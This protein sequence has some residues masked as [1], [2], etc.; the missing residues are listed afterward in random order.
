MSRDV[1][2][3]FARETVQLAA[4]KM[5]D[6]NVGFLPVIDSTRRVLGAITDRD[7][8]V[9]LVADDR[10]A[11]TPV[12]EVM[13]HAVVSCRATDDLGVAER[14]MSD[15]HKS[16]VVCTDD[17]GRLVGVVSL[18]DIAQEEDDA[19]LATTMREV[20]RRTEITAAH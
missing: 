9:R 8:V 2:F 19:C 1:A 3:V 4:C 11:R 14:L 12:D 6:R 10:T 18:S 7:I 17:S 16:R 5:R 15:Y 13:T 20:T